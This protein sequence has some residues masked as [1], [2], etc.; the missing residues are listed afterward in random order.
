MYYFNINIWLQKVCKIWGF[1]L[2]FPISAVPCNSWGV[3]TQDNE[4]EIISDY[5]QSFFLLLNPRVGHKAIVDT[6]V[7]LLYRCYENDLFILLLHI[8]CK[9]LKIIKIKE[10]IFVFIFYMRQVEEE[11][12]TGYIRY[13]KFEPVMMKILLERRQVEEENNHFLKTS[14]YVLFLHQMFCEYSIAWFLDC[15][16]K[17][18]RWLSNI[19][20]DETLMVDNKFRSYLRLVS[21]VVIV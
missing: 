2:V 1:L 6:P 18:M 16:R 10:I 19:F 13:E 4:L 21:Y 15:T 9:L 7:R 14:F 5:F 8:P 12:P 20:F 3:R 11:E 17:I